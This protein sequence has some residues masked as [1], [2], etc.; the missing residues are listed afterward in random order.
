MNG[1]SL[2]TVQK[3]LGNYAKILESEIETWE[4]LR[5]KAKAVGIK[6]EDDP[7]KAVTAF[8]RSEIITV[9]AVKAFLI[10]KK[11]VPDEEAQGASQ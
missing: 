11:L 4:T 9:R 6:E 10:G 2:D 3:M 7:A 5:E 8:Y 1:I